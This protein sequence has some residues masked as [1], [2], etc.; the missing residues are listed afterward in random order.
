ML[1]HILRQAQAYQREHGMQ[2][3]VVYLNPYHFAA[4][5]AQYP[6]LFSYP[7][8]IP[9]GFRIRILPAESLPHPRVA[10]LPPR[11]L[12]RQRALSNTRY[13]P[14]HVMSATFRLRR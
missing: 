3:N 13:R 5:N 1:D 11:P 14:D 9:L 8:P 4:L 12:L 6:E 7:L 10:C 2:P